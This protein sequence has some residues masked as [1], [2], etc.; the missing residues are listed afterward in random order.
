MPGDIYVITNIVEDSE[1]N[2]VIF[3]F[4]SLTTNKTHLCGYNSAYYYYWVLDKQIINP[5]FTLSG[6]TV[7]AYIASDNLP[8]I[9]EIL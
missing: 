8:F 6:A 4:T 2:E 9:T 7:I 1:Q 3:S 5:A